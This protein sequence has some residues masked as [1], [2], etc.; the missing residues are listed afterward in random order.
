VVEV[1]H[2]ND[3]L[4][5]DTDLAI[6]DRGG[7]NGGNLSEGDGVSVS[8][9][10]LVV[11]L[12]VLVELVQFSD[13]LASLASY[14][15]GLADSELNSGFGSL[16]PTVLYGS[17][18]GITEDS[19]GAFQ[20]GAGVFLVGPLSFS[21]ISDGTIA[22]ADTGST[23]GVLTS[24]LSPLAVSSNLFDVSCR[25]LS[26]FSFS[27]HGGSGSSQ[28][29]EAHHSLLLGHVSPFS[30]HG[31]SGSLSSVESFSST[32]HLDSFGF[33]SLHSFSMELNFTSVSSLLF[34]SSVSGLGLGLSAHLAFFKLSSSSHFL[35]VL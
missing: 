6:S 34:H 7:G 19:V 24:T 23:S 4:L 13:D 2:V 9:D 30:K 33:D 1:L 31:G 14:N 28:S 27:K 22:F 12:D 20:A 15:L 3:G 18:D 16:A 26:L 25:A 10:H 29:S 17:A 8:D 32:G 21:S 5:D 11:L 35:F